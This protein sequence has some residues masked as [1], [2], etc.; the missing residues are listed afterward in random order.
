MSLLSCK[1]MYAYTNNHFSTFYAY[2]STLYLHFMI[3]RYFYMYSIACVRA[4][5]VAH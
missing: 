1:L 2:I 4:S 5:G 3:T